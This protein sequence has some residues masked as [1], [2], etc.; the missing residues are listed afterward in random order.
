MQHVTPR[1]NGLSL[2]WRGKYLP[3]NAFAD[4]APVEDYSMV[5]RTYRF[6]RGTPLYP[7]GHGLSYTTFAY[8][9]LRT[10]AGSLAPDSTIT[11]RVDVTNTGRRAGDKVV[12]LY[13][14]HPGSA[15]ERPMKELKGY[16]RLTL[17]PRETRTVE[18]RLAASSL[19][20]WNPDTH[21]WVVEEG[22]VHLQVGASSADIRL[23]RTIR[24]ATG[25]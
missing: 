16:Q 21:A 12:Q 4:A 9:N 23:Q 11:V 18:F 8:R 7:F 5:G 19:A 6:F 3:H 2:F 1:A 14:Q 13:V 20:Y 25:R 17:Q 22:Q 24:I 10:S 15:V